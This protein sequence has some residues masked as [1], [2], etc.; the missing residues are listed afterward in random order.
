MFFFS[1]LFGSYCLASGIHSYIRY[2]NIINNNLDGNNKVSKLIG[3]VKAI[4]FIE[5]K[6]SIDFPFN[7]I[8]A[9]NSGINGGG[10]FGVEVKL[11][12]KIGKK[13]K[14]YEIIKEKG[15]SKYIN[16]QNTLTNVLSKYNVSDSQFNTQLPIKIVEYNFDNGVY[17]LEKYAS[18]N[19]K[20]IVI[21]Y[22]IKKRY[23][24]TLITLFCGFIPAVI[25]EYNNYKIH[26]RWYEVY[27]HYYE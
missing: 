18:S 21:H 7:N 4:E 24:L 25:I 27:S 1:L 11:F 12:S 26:K 9:G 13:Y 3:A 2:R 17:L 10:V 8:D 14:N 6:K 20:N 22:A 5:C 19:K 23:P 16:S 15:I